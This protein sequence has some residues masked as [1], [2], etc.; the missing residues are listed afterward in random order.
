MRT[1]FIALP[2]AFSIACGGGAPA[3]KKEDK[4]EAA[5]G[6]AKADAPK[7]EPK[8]EGPAALDL[9]KLGLTAEA[10]EGAAA[11]DAIVGDGVMIQGPGIVVTVQV[12][13][14][15]YPKTLEDAKKEA[16]EMYSGKE[17]K[18]ETLPDGWVIVW[19]NEGGLGKNYWVQA[20]RDIDGKSYECSTTASQPE[21]QTNALATCKSLKKK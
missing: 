8:K 6:D 7:E 5:K 18:E 15:M 2:L 11:G 19:E 4:K 21:Q 9:A 16:T 3:D 13:G 10:P 17:I 20:R 12:A 14:E 1:L